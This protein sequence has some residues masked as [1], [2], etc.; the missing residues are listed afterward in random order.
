ME[1]GLAGVYSK[2]AGLPNAATYKIYTDFGTGAELKHAHQV[3]QPTGPLVYGTNKPGV[4][5]VA[6]S[7]GSCPKWAD[8]TGT[9]SF[10][11][12]A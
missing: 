7:K 8:C 6:P 12:D 10:H 9:G 11:V 1:P 5:K 4:A 2:G 3:I